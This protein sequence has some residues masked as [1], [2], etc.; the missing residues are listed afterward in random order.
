MAALAYL[1]VQQL[2]AEDMSA[3]YYFLF[4]LQ[5]PFALL[6]Y[7]TLKAE[8]KNQFKRAGNIAK[9]IMFLSICYL[10]LFAHYLNQF[11]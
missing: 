4:L 7:F 10:F 11:L 2:K 9:L 8:T 1:Q 6:I 5:L 3:L